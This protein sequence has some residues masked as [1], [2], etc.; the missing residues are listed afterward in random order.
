MSDQTL[1]LVLFLAAGA[2]L[3]A[4]SVPLILRKIPPNPLYGFRVRQTL[5]DPQ[6]WY[7]VNAYSGRWLLGIAAA[8]IV[9]AVGLYFVPGIDAAAYASLVGAVAVGGLAIGLTQSF[10]CL[11]RLV[12]EKN[13]SR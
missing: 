9:A 3:A 11:F 6:I 5:D 2:V 4:V 1:L 7:P 12:R 8:V 10:R 13:A